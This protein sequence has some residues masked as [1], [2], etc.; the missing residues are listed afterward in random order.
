MGRVNRKRMETYGVGLLKDDVT[1]EELDRFLG[2]EEHARLMNYKN[3]A[4][5]I[6]DRQAQDL[7]NLREQG[8]IDDFRHMELQKILYDFYIHQGRAERI[9]N[10][11]S[12]ASTPT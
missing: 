10:S 3:T 4:T 7:K 5:Q 8:L 12:P 1:M 11:P 2:P 9:K 6:I